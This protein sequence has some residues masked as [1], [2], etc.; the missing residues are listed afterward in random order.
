MLGRFWS[1]FR[2]QIVNVKLVNYM[3]IK[4]FITQVLP[5]SRFMVVPIIILGPEAMSIDDY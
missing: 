3:L 5:L 1:D 4:V 2:S